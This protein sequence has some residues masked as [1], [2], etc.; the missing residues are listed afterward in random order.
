MAAG[1]DRKH[2]RNKK[3]CERYRMNMTQ[4]QNQFRRLLRHA[5]K[6][7]PVSIKAPGWAEKMPRDWKEAMKRLNAVLPNST[8]TRIRMEMGVSAL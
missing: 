1:G 7:L 3:F 2:G 4:E 6:M 5:K 8:L